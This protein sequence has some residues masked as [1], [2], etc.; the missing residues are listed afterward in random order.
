MITWQR[1]IL[2]RLLEMNYAVDVRIDET[3]VEN[4]D[5]AKT[6]VFYRGGLW[7][8]ELKEKVESYVNNGGSVVCIGNEPL[9]DIKPL[10]EKAEKISSE[11]T[12]SIWF[13]DVYQYGEGRIVVF[14]TP[15]DSPQEFVD[16]NGVTFNLYLE[17]A[18]AT[19]FPTPLVQFSQKQ[20]LDVSVRRAQDGRLC[21]HL[22]NVSGPHE[23]E[24]VIK[25][26]D[27]VENVET[28][29]NLE[30]EPKKIRLE[31]SGVELDFSWENN[32]AKFTIPSIP[33]YEIVVVE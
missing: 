17:K 8:N 12:D 26:I 6:V 9:E 7:S 1:P 31:P 2:K 5:S 20:P 29:L 18:L 14:P 16:A 30:S 32:Q 3:L 21:V 27:P 11:N 23:I 4:I 33:V 28:T 19:A 10:L 22:V 13:L 15:V 25:S 24:P